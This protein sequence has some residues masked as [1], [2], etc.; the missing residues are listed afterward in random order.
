M[1]L[2]I[3]GGDGRRVSGAIADLQ[4]DVDA[5]RNLDEQIVGVTAAIEVINRAT[6]ERHGDFVP[7]T[8]VNDAGAMEVNDVDVHS[9]GFGGNT[10]AGIHDDVLALEMQA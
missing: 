7:V 5:I 10:G 1:N 3:A 2:N 9:R 4:H 6:N 8:A